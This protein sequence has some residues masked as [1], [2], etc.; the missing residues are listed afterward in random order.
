MQKVGGPTVRLSGE[1]EPRANVPLTEQTVETI[2]GAG[3]GQPLPPEVKKTLEKSFGASLDKV[4]VHTDTSAAGAAGALSARA[5]TV[6]NHIYLGP[7]EQITDLRLIAHEAAHVVQ[8][9]GAPAVQ[10][11]SA[12][13]SDSYEVEAERASK[14]VVA[15]E[16]FTVRERLSNFRMQ[17][18]GIKDAFSYIADKAN[19]IPGFRLLTI[20]VGVNPINMS[21]VDASPANVL[22]AAIE[23][24]PGG[25]L[26]TQALDNYGI[27]DKVANFVSEQ[28]HSLGMTGSVIKQAV[29]DFLNGLKWSDVFDLDSVYERGKHVVITFIDQV[30]NFVK[31]LASGIV[32]LIKDTILK[33]LAA[34][35]AETRGWDLLI[36]VLGKNPITDEDVPQ[37]AEALIG[38]FL[39]LIGEDE[40]FQNMKKSG[41][42]PRAR[43]WF[44][45]NMGTLLGFVQQIPSLAINAFKSLELED[46]ILLPNAFRKVAA[47]F[48]N[49]IGDFIRWAGNALW[50]LLEIIFEVVK[51]GALAYIK[52]TGSALKSILKNPMPFVGNLVN[53]A[54]LGF[55]NF[56][57]NF[58]T[59][60]KAG[61]LDWLT[62]SLPG[63]YIPK[64]F[65]LGEIVKLVFSVLG[66]S[67]ANVRVK[68][69]KVLGEPAVKAMEVGFD[70]VVT[71][72]TQGPAAAWEKIKDQLNTLKDQVISG[73]TDMVIEMV[74]KKAIPKIVAMFIPGAGFISAIISIYDTVMVF[75]NKISKIIQVVTGFID[76]I[77]NIAAGNI[78]SAAK[79]VE[80]TLAGLLSLAINFLAGFAG[81]G[82]VADKVMGVIQR[83]R[84]TV[85]KGLDALIN[86]I[87][88]MAKKL[89]A[90]IFG[91][92]KKDE[93][94]DQQ[95]MDDLKKAVAEAEQL[96][97][98]KSISKGKKKKAL[99][100]IKSKYKLTS[101]DLVS[102]TQE[103]TTETVHVQATI[104]PTYNSK[105]IVINKFPP[106]PTVRI[107]A[108]VR[109]PL[110]RP[111][112]GMENVL[113][114]PGKA[115]LPGY[116]RAHLLGPGFGTDAP[117]GV[118]YAPEEVNQKLQNSGI[119]HLIR[120]MYAQ[121]FPGAQFKVALTA[122]PHSGTEL[123]ARVNYKL[124]GRFP[125]DEWTFIFE[126]TI[127][128]GIGAS[129]ETKVL[130]GK[131]PDMDAVHRFSAGAASVLTARGQD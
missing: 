23:F 84:A 90:K 13:Q 109:A 80:S 6:G 83:V 110:P 111:K 50:N 127:S 53:A 24:I 19:M 123:L 97:A 126:Y 118:F 47:V 119:E 104:N 117:Q 42:L 51:P 86:W 130:Q 131:P 65:T 63:V 96:T 10:R 21:P 31:G 26:I 124:Y 85:D 73:I 35:A 113:E 116:Q 38:G 75:V 58:G 49:F 87:V 77:V 25:S 61:L 105:G 11:L 71:L 39:K 94:T 4:V 72:V 22:R 79:R 59:H 52:K 129:P 92:D 106:E 18:W 14:A 93:R 48:G 5:F 102:D 68:L 107:I 60:L 64:S 70:I 3:P 78:S 12:N 121:R 95:K 91:K 88:T 44:Q 114:T 128:V 27:I 7:G 32:K 108:R 122:T 66:L 41:A 62:G 8:Q 16:S 34:L 56:A 115:G 74:T 9:Q 33:P 89:F 125:G 76:S 55:Q 46:I 82:K 69:V 40:V 45:S 100:K 103:E 1:E 101:I 30:R 98:D 54:K 28:I 36:A 81:L 99:D 67:W 37:D 57:G 112:K 2:A 17:R 15:R 43:A 29:T 120:T 20:A